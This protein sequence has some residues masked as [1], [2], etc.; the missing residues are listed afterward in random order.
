[1]DRDLRSLIDLAREGTAHS[2]SVLADNILDF[3]ISPEGRLNDQDRAMM[4]DILTSLVHQM[5]LSLRR[6]L[7]QRLADSASAPPSLIA[8]LAQDEASVARPILQQSKLLCDAQLVE[9]VKHRTKEHQLSIAMRR[10][11]SELVSSS[12]ISTGDEDVIE[13]LLHNESAAIS[14]DAMAY[15]VAES[16]QH[17]QFQGPLLARE[18]LPASLAHRMFWWVSAALRNKILTDF[19]LSEYDIDPTLE[20]STSKLIEDAD[21]SGKLSID[22]AAIQLVEKLYADQALTPEAVINMLRKGHIAAYIAAM[23][24]LADLRTQIIRR[25]IFDTSIEP[26][27]ILCKAVNFPEAHFSTMALLL[28]HQNSD[29]RQST[30][31]LYEVLEIFRNISSDKARI[32]LRYWH[33]ESYLDNA[34]K[35]LAG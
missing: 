23:A 19:E 16:R 31:K 17:S 22:N 26:L 34:V 11:I 3:F 10:D 24:L 9:I 20:R 12:L 18:D 8:F 27:A 29:Q 6:D 14:Q 15:L 28:L 5:E 4:D 35:E 13:S 25:I 33:S 2:R 32:V 7:A 1:M 21:Q 30:T